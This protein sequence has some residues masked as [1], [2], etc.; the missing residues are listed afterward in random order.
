MTRASEVVNLLKDGTA[1]ST[2][3]IASA[4]GLEYRSAANTINS[5]K[6][7]NKIVRWGTGMRKSRSSHQVAPVT[8]WT[9]PEAK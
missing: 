2:S 3:E 8:L 9:L 5:L 4:L 6:R 7:T 1:R